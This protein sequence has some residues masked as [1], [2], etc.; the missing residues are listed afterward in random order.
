[1]FAVATVDGIVMIENGTEKDLHYVSFHE[2]SASLSPRKSLAVLLVFQAFTG[3][4]TVSHFF[5]GGEK[6]TWKVCKTHDDVTAA[7][8]ELHRATEEIK[9]DVSSVMEHFVI[10]LL[11]H[12]RISASVSV[13]G[14]RQL[15]FVRNIVQL[16]FFL[17]RRLRYNNTDKQHYNKGSCDRG[18]AI[19]PHREQPSSGDWGWTY[20]DKWQSLWTNLREARTSCE[21]LLHC[22]NVAGQGAHTV[23]TVDEPAGSGVSLGSISTNPCP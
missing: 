20:L 23:V 11:M 9:V 19:Q 10:G 2:V 13:H 8:Y 18:V 1:M 7:F 15:L 4:D 14:T 12:D 3:C 6:T 16:Q 22:C 5:Q 17:H 21:Q